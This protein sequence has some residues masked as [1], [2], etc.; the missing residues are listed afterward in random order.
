MERVF[1]FDRRNNRIIPNN[2][3]EL[4]Q[5]Y[6]IF[7]SSYQTRIIRFWTSSSVCVSY[8]ISTIFLPEIFSGTVQQPLIRFL[9]GGGGGGGGRG[10][11]D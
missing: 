9:G 1:S 10:V 5:T 8:D 11:T 2:N 7:F 6:Q 4:F 3:S